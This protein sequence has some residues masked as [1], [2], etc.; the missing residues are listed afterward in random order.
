VLKQCLTPIETSKILEEFHGGLVRGHYGNNTTLNFFMSNCY[1]W[2]TI[3]KDAVDLCQRHLSTIK[4]Y[5][6]KWQGVTQTNYDI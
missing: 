2:L 4:T 3:H 1:W 6:A 5:V